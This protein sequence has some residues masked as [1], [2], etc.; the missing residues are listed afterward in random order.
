[1]KLLQSLT[2]LFL[3]STGAFYDDGYA[4]FRCLT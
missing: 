4:I 2:L 3:F 1:V